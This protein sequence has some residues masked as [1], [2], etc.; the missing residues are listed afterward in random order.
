MRTII[1]W[2]GM[3]SQAASQTIRSTL[4]G[5][6]NDRRRAASCAS[7]GMVPLAPA[8]AVAA[9][10]VDQCREG[11]AKCLLVTPPWQDMLQALWNRQ[12]SGVLVAFYQMS[13]SLQLSLMSRRCSFR[14]RMQGQMQK[15]HSTNLC[16]VTLLVPK[17][18]QPK[19]LLCN[20]MH[21]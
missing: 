11:P 6:D 12:L 16:A 1:C 19:H 18:K 9:A 20:N 13:S 2:Q 3:Q 7:G 4:A 8:L 5:T 15:G 17:C 14:L 21:T 10:S